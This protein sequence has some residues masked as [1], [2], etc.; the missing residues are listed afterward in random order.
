LDHS[1]EFTLSALDLPGESYRFGNRKAAIIKAKLL[2]SSPVCRMEATSRGWMF[3]IPAGE[4]EG[5]L[6]AV[7]ESWELQLAESRYLAGC[8]ET[9]V[10]LA[11]GVPTAPRLTWPL[12]K[13]GML[14]IGSAAA[15][16]DPICGDGTAHAAREGILA[17]AALCYGATEEA[18]SHYASR[19]LAAFHKHLEVSRSYYS[20]GPQTEWWR[21]QVQQLDEGLQWAQERMLELG[22]PRL[23]LNRDR[24]EPL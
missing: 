12:F 20:T 21:E 19:L 5:Y 23:R 3:L 15:A 9:V 7:G 1:P 4:S 11:S 22:P 2:D 8:L 16:F 17:A 24:L 14:A 6:I 18:L 10:E 13:E